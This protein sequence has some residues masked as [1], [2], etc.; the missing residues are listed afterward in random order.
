MCTCMYWVDEK[1]SWRGVEKV[2]RMGVLRATATAFQGFLMFGVY[3]ERMGT[4]VRGSISLEGG[5]VYR[6]RTGWICIRTRIRRWRWA[7]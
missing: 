2:G 1:E 3:H 7:G 4:V 5:R 6:G